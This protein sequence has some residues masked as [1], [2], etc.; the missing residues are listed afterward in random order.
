MLPMSTRNRLLRHIPASTRLRIGRLVS[1]GTWHDRP[2]P[3]GSRR[4][5]LNGRKIMWALVLPYAT[6]MY[7]RQRNLELVTTALEEANVPYF[8]R[9]GDGLRSS[10]VVP[11]KFV[12]DA[13]GMLR[14]RCSD[15]GIIESERV[16][17]SVSPVTAGLGLPPTQLTLRVFDPVT[18]PSGT[19]TLGGQYA[20]EIE[21]WAEGPDGSLVSAAPDGH[22]G[23]AHADD[24][25]TVAPGW[26]LC[27]RVSREDDRQ[28]RT[29]A[30]YLFRTAETVNFPID[31]V[32]TWVDRS[33]TDWQAR[34]RAA[35][36]GS[37]AE[38]HAL[39][40]DDSGHPGRDELRYALRSVVCNAPWIRR[41]FLVTADQAPPWLDLRHPAITVVRHRRIFGE[42]G[43]LPT[44]NPY[45][46]GAR[47]HHIPGLAEHFIYL[48]DDMFLGRPLLPGQFFHANGL[49]K[50]FVSPASIDTRPVSLRDQPVTVAAKNDRELIAVRFGTAISQRMRHA[51]YALRRGVLEEIERE[52]SREVAA[53]A[54]HQFHHPADLSIPS[55]LAHHWAFATG[56]AVPAGISMTQVDLGHRD[57]STR[58]AALLANRR[59]DVFCLNDADAGNDADQD[60][61]V[62]AF[63]RAYFPFRVPFELP[64]DVADDRAA[65]TPTA[66][67]AA[68]Y[69][70]AEAR[71]EPP[72]PTAANA[73]RFRTASHQATG[74]A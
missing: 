66:L 24:P 47:L 21:F 29:K 22:A 60:A 73:Y 35:L 45:A 50:F 71:Y 72:A 14:Q 20:C 25:E 63:L 15:A 70:A 56:R 36:V 52:L 53:T 8:C 26:K 6:P 9:P 62:V 4:P 18:S 48:N 17:R 30:S 33:D 49:A 39:A 64:D 46:I 16:K 51:P 3:A 57:T 7:V 74:R 44:F 23:T 43:V 42:A 13:T 32:F 41:I 19:W 31:A 11:A 38:M 59:H 37:D 61:T 10:V 2:Y 67:L 58:L 34:K 68:A 40:A 27:Q 5:V 65:R 12:N 55:S 28:F 54:S 69:A 1:S